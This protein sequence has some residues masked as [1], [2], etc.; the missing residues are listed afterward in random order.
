M[1]VCVHVLHMREYVVVVFYCYLVL[2][3]SNGIIILCCLSRE[4]VSKGFNCIKI[5]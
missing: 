3:I 4:T 1:C 2:A 5:L